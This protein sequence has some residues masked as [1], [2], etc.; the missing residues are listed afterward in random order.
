MGHCPPPT[1]GL[2]Q[3]ELQQLDVLLDGGRSVGPAPL[4]EMRLRR[5]NLG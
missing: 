4:R 5:A 2:R 1:R 3:L